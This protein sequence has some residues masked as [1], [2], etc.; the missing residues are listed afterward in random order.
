MEGYLL[1][2]ISGLEYASSGDV[3]IGGQSVNAVPPAKRGIAMVFQSYAL[4]PHL[5]VKGN[6][7]LALKQE[8]NQAP[9]PRPAWRK[10]SVCS[11]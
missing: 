6:M 9:K 3:T 4:Y 10:P 11:R 1:R 7:A 5:S 8:D 2:V